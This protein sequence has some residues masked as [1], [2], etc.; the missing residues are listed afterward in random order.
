MS[1]VKL[2]QKRYQYW[3]RNGIAWTEWFDYD[4]PEDKIQGKGLN[5]EYRTIEVDE[6]ELKQKE[7]E[8]EEW[9]ENKP[10]KRRRKV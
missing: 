1:K 5:N 7:T 9:L 10:K 4:G 3:S 6:S 8:F 2:K